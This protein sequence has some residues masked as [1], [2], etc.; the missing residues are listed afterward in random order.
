MFINFYSKR[1]LKLLITSLILTFSFFEIY[2]INKR[3]KAE[4]HLIAASKKDLLLYQQMGASYV[5]S[6]SKVEADINKSIFSA[7]STF[8]N[9]IFQRHGGVIKQFGDQKLNL[10]QL[11]NQGTFQIIG[12]VIKIC[13]EK[14]PNQIK[15]EYEKRIN[16]IS[17]DIKKKNLNN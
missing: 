3:I 8:A 15:N 11:Y 7:G 14:I 17:K 9:V 1:K 13:P 10:E 4:T 2:T 16:E 6:A 5:C 12:S